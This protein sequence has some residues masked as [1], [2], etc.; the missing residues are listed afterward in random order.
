[1]DQLNLNNILERINEEKCLIETLQHF[2]KNNVHDKKS[3]NE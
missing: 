1:M 2:E 3:E